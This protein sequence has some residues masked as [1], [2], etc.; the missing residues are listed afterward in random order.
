MKEVF[1]FDSMTV[2]QHSTMPAILQGKDVLA[3]A[4]TGI[5]YLKFDLVFLMLKKLV[6]HRENACFPRPFRRE[7][8]Q[9]PPGTTINQRARYRPHARACPPNFCGGR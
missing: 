6:R 7:S 9:P 5:V 2:V 1:G 3:R 8:V 4:K